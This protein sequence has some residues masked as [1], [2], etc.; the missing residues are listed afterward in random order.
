M[1]TNVSVNARE[2][3]PSERAGG[4]LV[5]VKVGI[6][7]WTYRMKYPMVQSNEEKTSPKY[8]LRG[9]IELSTI[10]HG[11]THALRMALAQAREGDDR[12]VRPRYRQPTPAMAAGRTS[13]RWTA[14][15]VLCYP[16]PPIPA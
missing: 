1:R 4:G 15:E 6:G 10:S 7:A 16:L 13:R 8:V 14:R 11:S 2:K 5:K 9:L 12:Q 3:T